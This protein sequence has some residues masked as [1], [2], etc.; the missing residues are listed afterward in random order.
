MPPPAEDAFHPSANRWSIPDLEVDD[1]FADAPI[2][3]RA[4][5]ACAREVWSVPDMPAL[6][7]IGAVSCALAAKVRGVTANDSGTP[8]R[9]WAHLFITVEAAS[10]ANKSWTADLMLRHHLSHRKPPQDLPPGIWNKFEAES[11][12]AAE[13]DLN[14]RTDARREVTRLERIASDKL[15]AEQRA[16][17]DGHRRRI[18]QPRI[19]RV[20]ILE[21]KPPS[22]EA[23]V[24]SL[25]AAGFRAVVP[26]EGVGFLRKFIGGG[27]E[28]EEIDDLINAFDGEVVGRNTIAARNRREGADARFEC[29][30]LVM[31]L[32]CQPGTL[33]PKTP[34]EEATLQ[35]LASRGLFPRMLF[36]RPRPLTGAEIRATRAAARAHHEEAQ[37]ASRDFGRMIR[38]LADVQTGDHPLAP[39]ELLSVHFTPEATAMRLDFKAET[40]IAVGLDGDDC[41]NVAERS[42]ARLQDH[43]CR[44]A[45][46]LAVL[47]AAEQAVAA[48]RTLTAADIEAARVEAD[49]VARAIRAIRGYFRPHVEAVMRRAKLD[50]VSGY[51][52]EAL[53]ILKTISRLA[54]GEALTKRDLTRGKFREGWGRMANGQD[55]LDLALEELER[56][57]AIQVE[58]I[59]KNSLLL[60][61]SRE[62]AP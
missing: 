56:V 30:H 13:R 26:N 3:R 25:Q 7:A 14:E 44:L 39:S 55:K 47:R 8:W 31:L 42:I 12:A 62:V 46:C 53:R 41:G 4:I 20:P 50:P 21:A 17:L 24:D 48:E 11:D 58:H 57:G 27:E 28:R 59:A 60:R 23:F 9:F 16:A 54:A 2:T 33:S 19:E 1:L 10:C 15:T 37:A 52:E 35:A 40:T 49:D 32:L 5:R 38:M 18:R 6:A 61:L 22:P 34:A 36:A 43:A 29:G 51:A 45:L